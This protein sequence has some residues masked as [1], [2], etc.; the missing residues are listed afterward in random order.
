MRRP[1]G[2]AVLGSTGSVGRNA[3]DV[4]SRFPGR[5]RVTALCARK[6]AAELSA[7]ARRFRPRIV[8][9]SDEIPPSRLDRRPGGTRVL[10]GEQGMTDAACSEGTEIVLA[11][12]AGVTSIRPVIA[13]ARKGKRIALANK[14]LLVLAGK[15]LVEAAKAGGGGIL[16]I[17]SEHSA[18]FQ[19]IEGHRKEDISRVILTAS[20]GPF[21]HRTFRQMRDATV[22]E[23]LGHPTWRMGAKI[24]IDSATLMNKGL[25]VIEAT[26]LFDLPPDRI[27]VLIHPQSIV[28]SLVEYRDG[29]LIAQLGI[30]DM[31]IP[32]G[33]ALSYP[34]RLP[35]ELP[36]LLPHRMD[37]W[38]FEPPDRKNFPALSLAYAAAKAGGTSP[39]ILNAANEVAV[40]AF[41]AGRIRFTDIVRVGKIL[42]SSWKREKAPVTLKDVL[43]ADAEAREGASRVI[44]RM[45]RPNRP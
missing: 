37:G 9:L 19:A 16:P 15:F 29:S 24:S 28:H 2:V 1:K 10:F 14:E 6:N 7:Q 35:L 21:R 42:M 45:R 23:A 41:L 13:A 18:V 34:E 3:L 8:C 12:A 40:D 33:Y 25:E 11:A 36:R 27:D 43:R 30:P 20:G 39:A 38:V 22:P 4:I 32:I 44:S 31:R 26:W 5:F 17:D